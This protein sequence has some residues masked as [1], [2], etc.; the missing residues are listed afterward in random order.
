MS[1]I[2]SIIPEALDGQRLDRVVSLLGD[3]SRSVASTLLDNGGVRVNGEVVSQASRRLHAGQVIDFDI[4]DH[5]EK[6]PVADASVSFTVVYCDD[7]VIVVDK[8]EGLVVHPGSG[9]LAGTLVNGLLARFPEI[10]DV[11]D[12]ER[13]GI[14]HRLDK[15][16]SGLLMVARTELA[17]D[18][19]VSQLVDH[20]ARREYLALV[21]GAPQTRQGVVDAPIGR[22]PRDPTRMAVVTAG[23]EARTHYEVVEG[24]SQPEPI[25]LVRCRLETGRTHQIRVHLAAIGH[26]VIGDP[27]YRGIRKSLDVPRP[28]LH[29]AELEF[30]HPATG[31]PMAFA[32][33]IP[34]D[35]AAVIDH[36]TALDAAAELE[37]AAATVDDER[38]QPAW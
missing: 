32:V 14:V 13:P 8:P 2:N 19:L 23:R 17:Y 4:P 15:G 16:T 33:P 37:S 31:E 12:P 6:R 21:W 27:L 9:N 20:S 24:F 18:E 1:N 25:S 30:I 38:D 7:D 35:M 34:D 36:I 3:V 29:A 5:D 10:A 11:G 28:M 22:S 26:S